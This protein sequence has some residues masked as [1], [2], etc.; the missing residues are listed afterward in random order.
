MQT[1][2]Q[3]CDGSRG[4]KLTMRRASSTMSALEPLEARRLFSGGEVVLHWNE[5]MLQSLTSQPPLLRAPRNEALVHVAMFDAVNAIDLSFEHYA[6]QV[7]ASRGA[8]QVAAAAQAAHDTL[9][10]LY[11][12]RQAVFDAALAEDLEGI[13]PGRAEQGIAIGREVARQILELRANDG[14]GNVVSYTPPNNDPGQWQPTPPDSSP[15]AGAHFSLMTPFAVQSHSQFLPGP[16]PALTSPE[17]AAAFN[18]AKMLGRSDSTVRT[19]DQTLVGRLWQPALPHFQVWNRVAQD[20]AQAS[21]LSLPQT[22][23]LF[24]LLDMTMSDAL[25]T[26]FTSKYEY[27]L[28]RPVTAIR[29]AGEDGNPATEA[30]PTWTTL[31][32]ATP[33]YPTYAGNAATVGA[34][35][36]AVLAGVFGTDDIAF[37]IDWGRYGFPGVTRPYPGFSAAANEE[38]DSRIY[39]GI[40]FRFDSVAGKQIGTDVAGYVME[41][42]LLP[43][44]VPPVEAAAQIT[45]DAHNGLISADHMTFQAGRVAARGPFHSDDSTKIGGSHSLGGDDDLLGLLS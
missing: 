13:P 15:A 42:F 38:A 11:P 6:A 35:S 20:V 45:L 9:V 33:P 37:N 23:R 41:N 7:H 26:S 21:E 4:D 24:A 27:E 19:A 25:A 29:R 32:P 43:R 1:L 30:D 39:G 14:S 31:H 22:A 16:P 28:W 5:I 8:S 34:A 3:V 18:E 44:N 40:H 12:S 2:Q 10:A 17:Y 36:A